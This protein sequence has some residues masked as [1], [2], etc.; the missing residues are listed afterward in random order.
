MKSL[1]SWSLWNEPSA[2]LKFWY[3]R[4]RKKSC[5]DRDDRRMVASG[6]L[7]GLL[8]R[9]LSCQ[10]QRRRMV[11]R[12]TKSPFPWTLQKSQ[13][14]K[15]HMI[16]KME[17][18]LFDPNSYKIAIFYYLSLQK[19]TP[20]FQLYPSAWQSHGLGSQSSSSVCFSFKPL[21][22]TNHSVMRSQASSKD[23]HQLVLFL[24]MGCVVCRPKGAMHKVLE[25]QAAAPLV[26]H[27]VL[28]R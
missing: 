28:T 1:D 4:K 10:F 27:P 19:K 6:S 15:S 20:K 22:Q 2:H 23:S 14:N 18:G 12:S 17:E 9:E 24:V 8:F 16:E 11:Q 25:V 5:L 21:W 3:H 7:C 26:V 13:G